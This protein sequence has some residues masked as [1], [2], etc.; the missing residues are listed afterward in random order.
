MRL[1]LIISGSIAV[2]KISELIRL[3]HSN[4]IIIDCIITKSAKSIMKTLKIPEP[5]N[6]N[7]FTDEDLFKKNKDFLHISLTRR[8]DLVLVCPASANIIGK[9]ANGIADDLATTT[10]ISSN[11]QIIFHNEKYNYLLSSCML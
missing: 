2:K 7:I 11:K 8:V 1:L 10:L 6:C 9:F 4:N 3:L 5:K